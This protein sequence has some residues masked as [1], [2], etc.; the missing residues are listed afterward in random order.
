MDCKQLMRVNKMDRW[1]I[2]R[3]VIFYQGQFLSYKHELHIHE[4]GINR[5]SIILRNNNF[6]LGECKLNLVFESNNWVCIYGHSAKPVHNILFHL[7][8]SFIET[9]NVSHF[10]RF[11]PQYYVQM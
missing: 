2:R 9:R 8:E 4:C 10:H 3:Q 6:I 5:Y 7:I 1:Y 11:T